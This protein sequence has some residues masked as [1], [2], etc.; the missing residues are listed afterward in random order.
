MYNTGQRHKDSWRYCVA[1]AQSFCESK[2]AVLILQLPSLR[3]LSMP[4]VGRSSWLKN[5][6]KYFK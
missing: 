6:T 5:Q 4:N 2:M 1:I 3:N